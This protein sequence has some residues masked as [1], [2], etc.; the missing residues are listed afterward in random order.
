LPAARRASGIG[1][2]INRPLLNDK[3]LF[4]TKILLIADTSN[5]SSCIGLLYPIF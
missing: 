1:M 3:I 2:T 4:G 5:M